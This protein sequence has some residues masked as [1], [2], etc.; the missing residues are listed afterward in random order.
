MM[1]I[2]ATITMSPITA[3]N[4]RFERSFG[5]VVATAGRACWSNGEGGAG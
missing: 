3:Q 5:S 2:N 4:S 1:T